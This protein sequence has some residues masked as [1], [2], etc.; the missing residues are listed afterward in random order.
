MH[1]IAPENVFENRP[2]IESGGEANDKLHLRNY[3]HR[4]GIFVHLWSTVKP[5]T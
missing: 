3:S 4:I 1:L 2:K 5:D